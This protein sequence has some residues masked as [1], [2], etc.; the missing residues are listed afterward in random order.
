MVLITML[1][2]LVGCKYNRTSSVKAYEKSCYREKIIQIQ[3]FQRTSSFCIN[4]DG[5]LRSTLYITE[6]YSKMFNTCISP[7]KLRGAFL[8]EYKRC[9]SGGSLPKNVVNP[10]RNSIPV[11]DIP[12]FT[13]EKPLINSLLLRRDEVKNLIQEMD[14]H[15]LRSSFVDI[16]T[17]SITLAGEYY[18]KDD[19]ENGMI[20]E[21]IALAA[22]DV[23]MSAIPGVGFGRDLYEAVTGRGLLSGQELTPF[24]RSLSILGV[25]TF[26]SAGAVAKVLGVFAKLAKGK[27]AGSTIKK[28]WKLLD[29]GKKLGITTK[30]KMSRV[31]AWLKK[32]LA[33]GTSSIWKSD[34]L[35]D[36]STP[37]RRNHILN[38]DVTGGGHMF[39]GKPTKTIFPKTWSGDKIMHEVAD[40]A[41]D[42]KLVWKQMTG[43]PGTLYTKGK[44]PAKFEVVGV[45]D[46][47]E[48]KVVF[49]PATSEFVTAHPISGPGVKRNP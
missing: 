44:K 45:K 36:L 39:P 20:A 48:I 32:P 5:K 19:L 16:S 27:N 34:A 18:S 41:T 21:G 37:A 15:A 3:R 28:T 12:K 31:I 29:S 43:V 13:A 23:A 14:D 49:K 6:V 22:L 1:A 24:D 47:V 25:V 26:G 30:K 42:P 38:G 46:G 7:A 9:G 10:I 4:S 40:I 17:R 11:V 8:S 33:S 2:S 35:V